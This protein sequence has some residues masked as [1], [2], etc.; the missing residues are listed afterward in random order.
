MPE[1]LVRLE[2]LTSVINAQDWDALVPAGELYASHAWLLHLEK[3][4]GTTELLLCHNTESLLGVLPLWKG[5]Q[6]QT[7]LFRLAD[8]F[9]DLKGPWT[10]N[11]LWLGT[12]R[13]VHNAITCSPHKDR[14]NSLHAL[15][16]GALSYAKTS[17]LAG[18]IMPYLPISAA[19]ELATTHKDARVVWHSAEANIDVP[20]GG[21][22]EL[23][24][25]TSS[26]NRRHRYR[27]IQQFTKSGYTI[28]WCELNEEIAERVSVLVSNT[29]SKY[30]SSQGS[31]WIGQIIKAQLQT[32]LARDARVCLCHHNNAIVAAGLCYQKA[33]SLHAR[34]FGRDY[35]HAQEGS[36]YFVTAYYAP[37]D[38]MAKHRLKR[39]CLSTSALEAKARRGATIDPLA[40]VVLFAEEV[41]LHPLEVQKHNQSFI[42]EHRERFTAYPSSLSPT[43]NMSAMESQPA[44]GV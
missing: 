30:G 7:G 36:T 19:M 8:F 31:N 13:S 17:G 37:I 42:N 10:K 15:L 34:Y 27:E 2:T 24:Q 21:L 43:W 29:R 39:F 33:D 9:P 5:E 35:A 6:D 40:A 12:Y 26:N 25:K 18:I 11:F 22:E 44:E 16:R 41:P 3:V 38:Y 28:E 20:A 14:A 1:I 32:G 23:L 4:L